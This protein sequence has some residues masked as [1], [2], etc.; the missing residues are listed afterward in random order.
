MFSFS[1]AKIIPDRP[2]KPVEN[3]SR[4]VNSVY[5]IHWV[6]VFWTVDLLI[7]N[8]KP[9]PYLIPIPAYFLGLGLSILSILLAEVW[10]RIKL[11]CK[12]KKYEKRR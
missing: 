6:L 11:N 7:Y 2:K 12:R 5:C 4:N 10:S 8:I 1:L 9:D 3:V